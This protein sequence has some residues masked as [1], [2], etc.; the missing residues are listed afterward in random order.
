VKQLIVAA[1]SSS[2]MKNVRECDLSTEKSN[3]KYIS[4]PVEQTA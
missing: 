3:F 1:A 2:Q 4:K